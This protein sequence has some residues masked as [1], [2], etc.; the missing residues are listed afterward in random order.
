MTLLRINTIEVVD[1]YDHDVSI[2]TKHIQRSN[3]KTPFSPDF[4][5]MNLSETQVHYLCYLSYQI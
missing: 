5:Q 4:H 3:R 1:R 2:M